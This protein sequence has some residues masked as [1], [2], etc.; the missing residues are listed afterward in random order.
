MAVRGLI[1][2]SKFGPSLDHDDFDAD[3]AQGV[4]V[5]IAR[6]AGDDDLGFVQAGQIRDADQFFGIAAGDASCGDV[7]EASGAT[8]R[9]QA[10]FGSSDVRQSLTDG[11][12]QFV[13]LDEVARGRFHSRHNFGKFDRAADDGKRATTVDDG[14]DAD[15]LV[16]V[17]V[18]SVHCHA[19]LPFGLWMNELV[20]VRSVPIY[21]RPSRLTSGPSLAG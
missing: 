13:V 18:A 15:G 8:R 21:E 6:V 3:A 11:F 10:P 12:G 1:A 7:L 4:V 14:F 20:T 17:L 19:G 5:G 16:Y 9:N 2:C